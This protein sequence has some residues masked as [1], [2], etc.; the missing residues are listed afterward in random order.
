MEK[1]SSLSRRAEAFHA[2]HPVRTFMVALNLTGPAGEYDE[3]TRCLKGMGRWWHQLPNVWILVTQLQLSSQVVGRVRPY[4]KPADRVLVGEL[5]RDCAWEG[6]SSKVE[7]WLGQNVAR[8][9]RPS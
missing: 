6:F 7:A 1:L 2:Q 5:T 9:E 3:L 4:L 8:Q